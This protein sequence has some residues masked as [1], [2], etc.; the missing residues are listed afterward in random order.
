MHNY[1]CKFSLTFSDCYVYS[2]SA[3]QK[4]NRESIDSRV[5]KS[6]ESESGK[7]DQMN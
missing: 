2:V 4:L 1:Y 5:T 6:G 3:L 7:A